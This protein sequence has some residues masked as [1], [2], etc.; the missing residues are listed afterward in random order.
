MNIISEDVKLSSVNM[1]Y[2]PTYILTTVLD[3]GL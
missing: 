1:Y 2:A 3:S